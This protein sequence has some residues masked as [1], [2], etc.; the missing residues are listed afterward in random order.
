MFVD[1]KSELVM[2]MR[3]GLPM[4]P[5]AV[6][7][8]VVREQPAEPGPVPDSRVDTDVGRFVTALSTIQEASASAPIGC[9]MRVDR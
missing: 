8:A 6:E 5:A 9:Q 3:L 2:V 7:G 4:S 1:P